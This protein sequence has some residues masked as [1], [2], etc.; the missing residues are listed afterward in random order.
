[1]ECTPKAILAKD[2]QYCR[3]ISTV[4]CFALFDHAT[5][6]EIILFCLSFSIKLPI[7]SHVESSLLQKE[8][9]V[10]EPY[11]DSFL[12]ETFKAN[13]NVIKFKVRNKFINFP[14]SQV[15]EFGK[16]NSILDTFTRL[17]LSKMTD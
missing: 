5:E 1:V 4:Q 11:C 17:P 14:F 2:I 3:N 12:T 9:A 13:G 15:I 8:T 6:N 7:A 10:L 16:D